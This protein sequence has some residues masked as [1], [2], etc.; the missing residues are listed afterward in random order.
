MRKVEV[1]QLLQPSDVDAE[2]PIVDLPH[3]F[4]TINA[5]IGPLE[6]QVVWSPLKLD[7]LLSQLSDAL[8]S[9]Y[10]VDIAQALHY[11]VASFPPRNPFFERRVLNRI[12]SLVDVGASVPKKNNSH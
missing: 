2:S 7:G 8:C 11:I 3:E 9:K 5:A 4:G 10:L 12:D 6:R 1:P